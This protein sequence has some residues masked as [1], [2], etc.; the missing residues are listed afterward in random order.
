LCARA[1]DFERALAPG[2]QRGPGEAFMT[3]IIRSRSLGLIQNGQPQT[4]G[5]TGDPGLADPL[6]RMSSNWDLV[7]KNQLGFNN[8]D[9]LTVTLSLR[10][11]LFRIAD[12]AAALPAWRQTLASRIVPDYRDIPEVRRF[13]DLPLPDITEP[14]IVIQ[15]GPGDQPFGTTVSY[16]M[17]V[18]G[19]PLGPGDFSFNPT[20]SATK[21][22]SVKVI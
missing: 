22:R 5:T 10:N 20:V 18:F 21:I 15:S 14:A 9:T 7:L 6:A 4:G 11:Q 1:Y 3:G 17:N 19:W 2:D 13:C 8:P 12:G 16:L